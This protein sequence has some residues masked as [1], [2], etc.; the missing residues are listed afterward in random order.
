MNNVTLVRT[1]NSAVQLVDTTIRR[2]L[3][4]HA[5]E[6]TRLKQIGLIYYENIDR[7]R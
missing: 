3:P 4:L 2:K 7:R 6:I 1:D 5:E